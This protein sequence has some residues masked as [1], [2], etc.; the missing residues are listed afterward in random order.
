[1]NLTEQLLFTESI[2]DYIFESKTRY[3]KRLSMKYLQPKYTAR[4]I[5]TWKLGNKQFENINAAAL[6]THLSDTCRMAWH[7]QRCSTEHYD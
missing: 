4:L 1:M 6:M 3:L 5:R 2:I 7:T